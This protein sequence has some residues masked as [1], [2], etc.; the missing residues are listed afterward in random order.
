MAALY[1]FISLLTS[2]MPR[3]VHIKRRSKS[4]LRIWSDAMLQDGIG[5]L[6]FAFYDPEDS[7]YFFSS[8]IVPAWMFETFRFPTHCIG[9]LEIMAALFVYLTIEKFD[10]SRLKDRDVLHWVDNTSA[11]FGL[12]K[13][14]SASE[15]S[16]RLI[17]IFH[18]LMAK[19]NFRTWWEYVAS[20]A[21]LADLPSRGDFVLLL[22]WGATWLEPVWMTQ[23]MYEAPFLRWLVVFRKRVRNRLSGGAQRRA[24][25]LRR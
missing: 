16:S 3:L 4:A 20:S 6:G 21:N 11:I 24:R 8:F 13:G 23:T 7:A 18:L 9:Q 15:D 14:Y 19:L 22:Q 10:V 17:Q 12:Y 2:P 1:F 25:A 5:R